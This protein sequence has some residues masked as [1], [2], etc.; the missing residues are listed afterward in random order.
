MLIDGNPN[1]EAKAREW[2]RQQKNAALRKK[3]AFKVEDGKLFHGYNT[4]T[5]QINAG[6]ENAKA[7]R[8]MNSGRKYDEIAIMAGFSAFAIRQYAARIGVSTARMYRE[9][10]LIKRMIKDRDY[11]K[12]RL[13][14][15]AA[16]M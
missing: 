9:P 10:D 1:D 15:N 12:F 8:E 14:D 2:V 16:I 4:T 11:A 13:N 6:F 3:Y 5:E 7:R